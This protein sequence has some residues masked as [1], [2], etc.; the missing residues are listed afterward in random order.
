MKMA[1]A[2]AIAKLAREP[3]P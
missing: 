2:K 1:A 3:I